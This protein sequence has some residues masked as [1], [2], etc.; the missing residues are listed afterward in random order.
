MSMSFLYREE[1]MTSSKLEYSSV[2]KMSIK[3][4]TPEHQNRCIYK[5]DN[6][7]GVA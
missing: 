2:Q 5:R 3:C 7:F 4:Y 1:I 6:K